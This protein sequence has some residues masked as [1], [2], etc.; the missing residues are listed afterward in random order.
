MIDSFSFTVFPLV[1]E[2]MSHNNSIQLSFG[3]HQFEWNV[4]K[5]FENVLFD[6]PSQQSRIN[7]DVEAVNTDISFHLVAISTPIGR[8]G[9]LIYKLLLYFINFQTPPEK[10]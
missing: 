5:Y 7:E 3:G 1:D 2:T 9:I 10:S 4:F 6:E 8:E